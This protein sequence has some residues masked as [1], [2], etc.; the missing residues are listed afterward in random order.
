MQ[1][2]LVLVLGMA[3]IAAPLLGAGLFSTASAEGPASATGQYQIQIATGVPERGT[4]TIWR[5][6]TATGALDFC[7]FTNI[8]AP[9]AGHI[10][11][12]GNPIGK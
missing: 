3:M 6:N 11:C 5:L 9:G 7:T 10:S 1:H 12:Q 4:S 2:R 8:T